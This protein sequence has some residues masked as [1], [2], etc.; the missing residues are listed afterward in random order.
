[1]KKSYK[2]TFLVICVLT[3]VLGGCNSN[4]TNKNTLNITQGINA[5]EQIIN[6]DD[7]KKN[8][9]FADTNCK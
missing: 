8:T 4:K 6:R 5:E 7:N 1:M 9:I 2:K 3:I